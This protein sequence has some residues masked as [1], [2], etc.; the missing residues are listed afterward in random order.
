[1]KADPAGLADKLGE[2]YEVT[3]TD[4]KKWSA[5][6]PIQAADVGSLL[7]RHPFEPGQVQ[8]VVM[9]IAPCLAYL[10]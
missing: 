1:L 10:E 8:K 5:G 2:R 4:I 9:Q 3:R 6:A 7:K